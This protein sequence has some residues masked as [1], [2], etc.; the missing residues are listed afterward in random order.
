MGDP[1]VVFR[2][3]ALLVLSKPSGLPTTSPDGGDCLVRRAKSLDPDA[4]HLH[5]TSRLDAEVTGL[6][7]FARTRAANFDLL[8]ARKRGAYRRLYLALV[9]ADAERPDSVNARWTG[10]IAIDP[11]D[12]RK[13]VVDPEGKPSATRVSILA[14]TEH[15]RLLA[16][17]PETGR[18]HQIRVHAAH[19]GC[20]ILGDRPYGGATRVTL[21]NGRVL[22]ARRVML[23]CARVE[24]ETAHAGTLRFELPPPE[25]FQTISKGV[26]LV[27]E[28]E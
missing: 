24:L 7:T 25:D 14:E 11:R 15:V 10:A 8:D 18:T 12:P 27:F 1:H 13:R 4:E 3:E 23:H 21:A 2:D 16:L 6:V 9:L 17:R 28:I 20:P 22:A 19:A 26:G 5:A